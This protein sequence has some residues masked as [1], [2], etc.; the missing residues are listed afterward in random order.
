VK[1]RNLR[2]RRKMMLKK[3]NRKGES[4]HIGFIMLYV[5]AFAGILIVMALA[6]LIITSELMNGYLSYSEGI[7]GRIYAYR[8]INNCLAYQDEFTGRFYPGIID[9]NKYNEQHLG[10]CFAKTDKRSF[11][12][13]LYNLKNETQ[14]PQ[15]LVGFGASLSINKYPVFIRYDAKTVHP[16]E[17]SFGV[18]D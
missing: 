7:R 16:G 15:L 9:L 8:A 10:E 1:I 12:L 2:K 3:L 11:N 13:Q 4:L 6:L 18:S 5:I 17:L 14:Y